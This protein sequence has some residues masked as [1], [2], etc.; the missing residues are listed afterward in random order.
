MRLDSW[1][2]QHRATWAEVSLDAV[3]SNTRCLAGL[4]APAAL[5]AVVKADAYGH[6]AVQVARAALEAGAS[7]LGVAAVE[8]AV[9]LRRAGL[10]APILVL[11]PS[12]PAHAETLAALDVAA[13]VFDEL[14]AEALAAAGRRAGRPARAHLK[15]D[16]GMGRLG[17]TPDEAGVE[18]AVRLSR[19]DGLGL[20]GVYTH[21]ATA[22]E[23]QK[24]F[25]LEQ[26]RRFEGFL[27]LCAAAGL[28]FRWRHAANTA[29]LL[30]L[31]GTRYDLVRA[32]IALYGLYPSPA[33]DRSR[34]VLTPVLTWKTRLA[35][36]KWVKPGASVSYGRE[37]VAR[38][39]TLV[40]T[41]PVGYADGYR[42][43]LSGKGRV[44]VRGV[45]CPILGR[46]CMD[47]LMVGLDAVPD[48]RPGDEAVLLGPGLPAEELAALCGTI[49][50]EIVSTLGRRVPRVFLRD[51]RP[52]AVRSVLGTFTLGGGPT[53]A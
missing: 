6:G 14:T 13:A 9:E 23:A 17:V 41:L 30:D 18:L 25:A 11:G 36:V 42:R 15:V 31:P 37:F 44:L 49:S 27:A 33:V 39:A 32:G 24:A 53:C 1:E 29:A 26:V 45:S 21:F 51:G 43:A 8:E 3:A 22:D 12:L 28:E 10:G 19:L 38:K 48:A 5:M 4:A 7:W 35:Q 34:A 52:V 2:A 16:T 20:E 50:Y 40:G 46:V 47:H